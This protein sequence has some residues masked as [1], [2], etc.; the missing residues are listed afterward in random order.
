MTELPAGRKLD[1]R[2]ADEIF[3]IL[4]DGPPPAFST[5]IAEAW[6]VVEKVALLSALDT[7]YV[8]RGAY[9]Y[10]AGWEEEDVDDRGHVFYR[11]RLRVEAATAPH[12][13]CLAALKAVHA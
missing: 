8:R 6:L 9:R 5:D 3:G 4:F 10:E 12:A 7:F 1:V 13:I 2:I 11:N